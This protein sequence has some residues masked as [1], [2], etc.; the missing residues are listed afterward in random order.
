MVADFARFMKLGLQGV[1]VV[2][3]SGDTG[4]TRRGENTTCLDQDANIFSPDFPAKYDHSIKIIPKY[5]LIGCS[6]S[7]LHVTSVGATQ[8]FLGKTVFDSESPAIFGHVSLDDNKTYP[9]SSSGGGFSNIYSAPWYQQT[10]LEVSRH[11]SFGH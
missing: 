8:G 5:S 4:V 2:I 3:A 1:T 11:P 7:C 10:A 6:S 9:W